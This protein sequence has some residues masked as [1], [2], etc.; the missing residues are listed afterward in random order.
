MNKSNLNVKCFGTRS[1]WKPF[2]RLTKSWTL[3]L[4][5]NHDL[6]LIH[7]DIRKPLPQI[8]ILAHFLTC[9]TEVF[10]LTRCWSYLR[11]ANEIDFIWC[12]RP[13]PPACLG[14][15]PLLD[16]IHHCYQLEGQ[17]NT[18]LVYTIPNLPQ[19]APRPRPER[20][21][22]TLSQSKPKDCFSFGFEP[23]EVDICEP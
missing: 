10:Y 9:P 11:N 17:S 16:S 6:D 1:N 3:D 12:Q 7:R 2:C 5:K 20:S 22:L 19:N 13:R 18:K 14:A 15:K 23:L 8:L 4:R 21:G